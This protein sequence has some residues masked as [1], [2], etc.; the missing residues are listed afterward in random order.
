MTTSDCKPEPQTGQARRDF[1][2]RPEKTPSSMKSMA[3]RPHETPPPT[4]SPW[5]Q[6]AGEPGQP[7]GGAS[8]SLRLVALQQGEGEDGDGEDGADLGVEGVE[9]APCFS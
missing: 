7:I 4:P 3:A 8:R 2:A 1:Q 5:N 6:Q 9:Q